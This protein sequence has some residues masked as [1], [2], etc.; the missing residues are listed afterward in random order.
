[1]KPLVR[2]LLLFLLALSLFAQQR[3][4]AKATC[5][6]A[7]SVVKDQGGEAVKKATIQVISQEAEGGLYSAVTD[8]EGQFTLDSLAPGRY[9]VFV[10]RTGFIEVDKHRRHSEGTELTLQPGQHIKGV[11]LRVVPAAVITGRVIDEDGD[12]MPNVEISVLRFSYMSGRRKMATERSERTNDL[13]EYRIGG[14]LSDRYFLAA[15]PPPDF[16]SAEPTNQPESPSKPDT[17]YVTTYYPGTSDRSQ[18]AAVELHPGDETKID[19]S[20]VRSQTFRIRGT[21]A[22]AASASPASSNAKS[23][24]MLHP[25]D[26]NVVFNAAEVD[27]DGTF[28]IR[29]VAPGSYMISLMPADGDAA[30]Q[31][32]EVASSDVNNVRLVPVGAS[33]VRGQLRVE[34]NRGIDLTLFTIYLRPMEPEEYILGIAS[35]DS[36]VNRDGTFILDKVPPG[37]YEVIAG[38]RSK[39]CEECFVKS[40]I[41]G[42][43]DVSGTGLRT[44]GGTL[45]LEVVVSPASGEVEGAVTNNNNQPVA[46]A[47]VVAIPRPEHRKQMDRYEK[48]LTDQQGHFR[49]RGLRPDD[50]ILIAWEDVEDG[51]WYDP[52]FLK[53]YENA[54]QEIHLGESGRQNLALQVIPSTKQP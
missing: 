43:R 27:K 30:W 23:V 9:R 36:K 16:S 25:K 26:F 2:T 39:A 34:G 38:T 18:A 1:M 41:V 6:L 51:A 48:S 15:S 19:F 54:G 32:L 20:L 7:G 17:F 31:S 3:D 35:A 49:L 8:G 13:G 33:H 44:S 11:V 10:E 50:Y 37:T 14:L 42:G 4:Q 22:D 45:L 29:G 28:E 24:V 12:P 5:S 53:P 46:N 21:V 47:T 40:V 52:D